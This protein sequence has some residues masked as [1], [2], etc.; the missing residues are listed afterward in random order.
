MRCQSIAGLSPALK[1]NATHLYTWA[2]RSIA[3]VLVNC[4]TQEHNVMTP[5]KAQTRIVQSGVQR[6][7][8]WA[9]MASL[10]TKISNLMIDRAVIFTYS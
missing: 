5:A 1:F 2:E 3:R 6:A 4:L 10:L 8:H 7:D 9:T